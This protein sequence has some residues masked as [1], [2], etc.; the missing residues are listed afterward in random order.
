M[1]TAS[2]PSLVSSNASLACSVW[3]D[4]QLAD[5]KVYSS[6]EEEITEEAA[7]SNILV[8]SFVLCA[9]V[10]VIFVFNSDHG[11]T[12]AYIVSSFPVNSKFVQLASHSIFPESCQ[13]TTLRTIYPLL[14]NALFLSL[15]SL[16]LLPSINI[17]PRAPS[18]F[19]Y[20]SVSL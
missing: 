18:L 3:E 11:F 8:S 17:S 19:P 1:H 10:A 9:T 13:S 15:P 14:S 6:G 12:L 20:L 16:S 5:A 2:V 4:A 7:L